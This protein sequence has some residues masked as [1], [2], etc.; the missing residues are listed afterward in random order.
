M[1]LGKFILNFLAFKVAIG[2]FHLV[3]SYLIYKILQK[4]SPKIANF[5]TA[6]YALNPLFLIEGVANAHNDV[7]LAAFLIMPIYFAL[8]GKNILS[9]ALLFGGAAIKYIPILNLP[10]FLAHVFIPKFR[11]SEK[12]VWANLITMTIFTYLF[13]SFKITVPFV[14]AGSTQVQ[15]QP[16]Y[17]FWT[18]PLVALM[19]KNGLVIAAIAISIGASLRYLPYLYYG[20]WSH[21]ETFE[22]MTFILAAS[23]AFGA[24][25]ILLRF[26][27]K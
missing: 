27:L 4:Q 23:A 1:G 19:P 21:P 26:K 11:H 2:A 9:Y 10:W 25:F 3:N 18:I 8:T 14:S 7:V 13:S 17:L 22:F 5:G 6:F 16:W 20:D 12:L 15:F 24:F